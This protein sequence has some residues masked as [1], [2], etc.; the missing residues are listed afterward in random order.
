MKRTIPV[1]VLIV[2][3]AALAV[4]GIVSIWP[5]VPLDSALTTPD[6]PPTSLVCS[7]SVD[8][9]HGMLLLQPA[10]S[11]RVVR[12]LAREKQTVRKDA[13]L[14]QL[15][16]QPARLGVEFDFLGEIRFVEQRLGNPDPPGISDLHDSGLRGHV[17]TV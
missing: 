2:G 11:G 10:R 4:V 8:S 16:D 12:V 6:A 15:D 3:L 9:R 14:L 5:H 17:I 7:G 1:A 13:P